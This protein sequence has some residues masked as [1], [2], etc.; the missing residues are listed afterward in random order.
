MRQYSVVKMAKHKIQILNH[1]FTVHRLNSDEKLPP[2]SIKSKYSWIA[3]TEDEFSVVCESGIQLPSKKSESNWAAIK[4]V[5]PLDFSEV[6]IIA[7]ISK[8]LA[9]AGIGIFALSTFD[10]DYIL[11]KKSKI[12]EAITALQKNGYSIENQKDN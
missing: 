7:E 12:E 2:E 6:G 11:I 8:I 9:E 1:E 5:G 10:T 3:K 4:I